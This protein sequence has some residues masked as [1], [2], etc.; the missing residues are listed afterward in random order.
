MIP[1]YILDIVNN[2]NH[3][4]H[5]QIVELVEKFNTLQHPDPYYRFSDDHEVFNRGDTI[6]QDLIAQRQQVI[7]Q[8]Q[9]L[10]GE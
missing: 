8:I 7:V 2:G 3:P 9:S 4:K 6:N 10:I 5:A 1:E